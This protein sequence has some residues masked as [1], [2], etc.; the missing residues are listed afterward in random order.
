MDM[1]YRCS[2]GR[3]RLLSC[4]I[5]SALFAGTG[6]G[7]AAQ[8]PSPASAPAPVPAQRARPAQPSRFDPVDYIRIYE[9]SGG[10]RFT[11]FD[12]ANPGTSLLRADT[13]SKI[14]I[15]IDE[16]RLSADMALNSLF[17]SAELSRLDANAS[18]TNVEVLNYS[19]IAQD[20]RTQAS[21]AGVALQ[22][23]SDVHVTLQNF[24]DLTR[25]LVEVAY[26]P[27]CVGP[28]LAGRRPAGCTF[29]NKPGVDNAARDAA[30]RDYLRTFRPRVNAIVD[31]FTSDRNAM[32]LSLIGAEVF[33]LDIRS[34]RG[35][36]AKLR[37]D[38][39]TFVDEGAAAATAARDLHT[40]LQQ[41][42]DDFQPLRLATAGQ[43]D[44]F[45]SRWRTIVF[46]RMQRLLAAGTIDLRKYKAGDG[47]T[48]RLTV[49]ARAAGGEGA[50][51]ISRDFR[52]ALRKLSTR[53]V[54]EPSAFYVRRLGEIR[55]DK[56]ET[57]RQRFA[58]APGVTFG[59]VFY[60]RNPVMAALTPGIG[61]NV[62]FMN[63]GTGD[64]DDTITDSAGAVVGGFKT[65]SGGSIQVGIG[66]SA[67]L[68]ANALQ[69]TWGYNMQADARHNYF[70][71][72]VGFVQ[73]G[74]ELAKLAKK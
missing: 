38:V 12:P 53:I 23:A 9:E 14:V 54:T 36:A 69:F 71:I 3:S 73:I 64:F 51:G 41:I 62:S 45:E 5:V 43:S 59:P 32:V 16:T 17:I 74:Q 35:M 60:S 24:Y 10:T 19:Q 67:S 21:Q 20:P 31:F 49:Q 58:P 61:L 48:L 34:L 68:F 4:L 28:P 70:G 57:V 37:Q 55:N 6:A 29:A 40:A 42:W 44:Y 50:G 13:D 15:E 66:V 11:L 18:T 8:T 2:R 52:I 39:S 1:S 25:G 30:L 72:G 65:S 56:G 7:V 27:A 26:E 63:F 22:T 47:E 46:P 33:S